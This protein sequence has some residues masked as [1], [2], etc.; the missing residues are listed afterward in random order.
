MTSIRAV[1]ERAKVSQATVSRALN[2]SGYVSATVRRAVEQAATDLGYRPNMHA[3]RLRG[4]RS[5][6]I[7]LI[8]NDAMNPFFGEIAFAIEDLARRRGFSVI[9]GNTRWE[10]DAQRWYVETFISY[11][12]DGLVIVPSEITERQQGVLDALPVPYLLLD[13]RM[14]GAAA[15]QVATDNVVGARRMVGHLLRVGHRRIALI[16]GDPAMPTAY[17]RRCGFEEAYAAHGLTPDPALVRMRDFS[18]ESGYELTRALL[19]ETRPDALFAVNFNTLVGTV[20]AVR[21]AALAIPADLAVV[22]FD[23]I[24]FVAAVA[25]FLTVI[26]QQH[27]TLGVMAAQLLLD[28]I[29]GKRPATEH[30][31]VLLEPELIVRESCGARL[32][33]FPP[34]IQAHTGRVAPERGRE[35]RTTPIPA[36]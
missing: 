22:G 10:F 32:R 4:K 11:G 9:V 28:R 27:R 12:V 6:T 13:Q 20:H 5:N 25:P 16:G 2:G 21:D 1:A 18:T 17:E 30:R 3:R 19:R 34:G 33:G 35:G 15:D 8:F 36:R 31:T 29:E 7:G 24:P 26:S 23:D 14:V